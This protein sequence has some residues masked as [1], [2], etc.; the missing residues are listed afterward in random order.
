MNM[1]GRAGQRHTAAVWRTLSAMAVC[2][3]SGAC[4]AREAKT[5]SDVVVQF[6]TMKEAIGI[7]GAPTAKEL[8]ALRP[9]ISDS[10]A[11]ALARADSVRASDQ[12]RAPNDKPSYVEGDLFSSLFE[13]PSE[14]FVTRAAD[15]AQSP[16]RVVVTFTN[17][18][19]KPKVEW[20]DT[21]IVVRE[22]GHWRLTDIHYG[23]TWDFSNKGAL[24]SQLPP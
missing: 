5:A 11:N 24:R 20:T 2:A 17:T 22:N 15:D 23:A 18:Q 4:R 19:K 16:V 1:L 6:F 12:Q 9:F 21:A 13:G 3:L 7:S 10:L 8:A 14:F